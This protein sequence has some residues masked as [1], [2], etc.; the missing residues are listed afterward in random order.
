MTALDRA[1]GAFTAEAAR[2]QQF[3]IASRGKRLPAEVTDAAGRP[4]P[5]LIVADSLKRIGEVLAGGEGQ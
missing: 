2:L 5:F 4:D 3:V 1:A